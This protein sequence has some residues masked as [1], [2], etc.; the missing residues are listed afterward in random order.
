MKP[1]K[2]ITTASI[3]A[4]SLCYTPQV[5]A[6]DIDQATAL[7][8][9]FRGIAKRCGTQEFSNAFVAGSR[10]QVATSLQG[11]DGKVAIAEVEAEIDSY[12]NRP[13]FKKLSMNDCLRLLPQLEKLHENRT[14]ALESTKEVAERLTSP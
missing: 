11:D 14:S 5:L 3:V 6:F 4:I 9:L 10:Q 13:E 1:C 12:A 7:E 2:F 8:G